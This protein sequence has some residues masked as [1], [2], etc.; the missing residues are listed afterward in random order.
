[1]TKNNKPKSR[2]EKVRE[3]FDQ[4]RATRLKLGKTPEEL[5]EAA[6]ALHPE[7]SIYKIAETLGLN[8]S[9]VK[10]RIINSSEQESNNS[11][12]QKESNKPSAKKEC[13]KLSLGQIRQQL[14]Y[15]RKNQKKRGRI[16]ENLWEAAV[17]LYPEY[18]IYQIARALRLDYASVK[19]RILQPQKKKT[20]PAT[21]AFIQVDI[22]SPPKLTQLDQN[23]W[24]IEMENADGAKMKIGVKSSQMLDI[25]MICQS[26]LRS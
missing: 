22:P 21:P 15:H 23:E 5:W 4:W 8:H 17:D 1:M 11:S 19:K 3:R 6:I 12:S 14:E 13:E 10:K 20:S 18:S 25:G 24:S 9:K 2:L 7:Y 16:P 26:F